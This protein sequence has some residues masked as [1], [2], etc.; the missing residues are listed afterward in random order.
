MCGKALACRG[1][2]R[3]ATEPV[4][5]LE[6]HVVVASHS[7]SRSDGPPRKP[8]PITL[9]NLFRGRAQRRLTGRAV[10][11]SPSLTLQG[12][13]FPMGCDARQAAAT[14]KARHVSACR[15]FRVKSVAAAV[16]A[17]RAVRLGRSARSEAAVADFVFKVILS[18][19]PLPPRGQRCGRS[20]RNCTGS[21][22]FRCP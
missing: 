6:V 4:E 2:R 21:C 1:F 18:P 13:R 14:N 3:S 17:A 8:S 15:A 20:S 9:E 7:P 19:T 11:R 22:L 5:S 10:S 12:C 16:G